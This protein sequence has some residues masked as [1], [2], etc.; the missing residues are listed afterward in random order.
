MH[1][2]FSR[3][4]NKKRLQNALA[5]FTWQPCLMCVILEEGNSNKKIGLQTETMKF[6]QFTSFRTQ[7]YTHLISQHFP[8][9]KWLNTCRCVFVFKSTLVEESP[10]VW[11]QT[12][13]VV[14]WYATSHT[15]N[16]TLI[17]LSPLPLPP[18]R[19]INKSI[20]YPL[21]ITGTQ[22]CVYVCLKERAMISICNWICMTAWKCVCQTMGT[23]GKTNLWHLVN[24]RKSVCAVRLCSDEIWRCG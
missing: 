1:F 16:G 23:G 11:G 17:S 8:T 24:V 13:V 18:L 9:G 4:L 19:L 21:A 20:K 7:I 12:D 10:P 3:P 2:S 5:S 22:V 14:I 6:N 15:A